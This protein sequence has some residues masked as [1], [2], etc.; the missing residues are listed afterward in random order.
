VPSRGPTL[1]SPVFA[2]FRARAMA[3]L[4]LLN[5]LWV[6]IAALLVFSMTLAVGFL[7]VG[8][9]G[10]S[11]YRSLLKTL[12]ISGLAIVVMAIVGF[13]IGFAP[14]QAGGLYGNPFYAQ[15]LF[16]GGFSPNFAATF[17]TPW[18]SMQ[19]GSAYFGTGLFPGTYFL[20][21]AAFASVTLALVGVVVLRKVKLTSFAA[22]AVVYFVVIWTIPAAWIW[23]PTGWLAKL[24]MVDFAG[25]LVVHG[26]A[27]AAGLGILVQVWREERAR[28]LSATPQSPM[29]PK[30]AWL[31]LS[32]LLL[33]MGWFGFNPGSVLQFNTEAIV[34]VLTTFIAAATGMLSFL[35]VQFVRGRKFADL[36]SGV[37]GTL[38]GLIVITPLAGF[39]SP[40]SA[41]VLG[42]VC[43]P[44]FWF[45]EV[46][47]SKLKWVSDPVGLLPGHLVGGLF[48]ILMIPFFAQTPF[49]KGSGYPNLPNGF[50]FGGGSAAAHQLGVEALGIVAVMAFVFVVSFVVCA[51][52][53][54]LS[55]GITTRTE[56]RPRDTAA[57][58]P[59][60]GH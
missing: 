18:W 4:V 24:G 42:A 58:S 32:I 14:T 53:A 39:V 21:E 47:C 52:I 33:W 27:G 40:G 9:L 1:L 46:Q 25:G 36:A 60:P 28:G 19:P 37:N 35:A 56:E 11:V 29:R 5:N 23:N 43:G 13:N 30:P 31:A 2:Q 48:G 44:L 20:F 15:G 22:Y 41:F 12:L 16:L 57:A 54:Q 34:V 51:V 7:E 17:A 26:A 55:G 38:M 3:E 59:T 10:E 6:L 49:A 45:A 8:E 50:F